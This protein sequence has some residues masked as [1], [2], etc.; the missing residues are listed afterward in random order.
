MMKLLFGSMPRNRDRWALSDDLRERLKAEV[1]REA[2]LV[3][4]AARE[5]ARRSAAAALR[6]VAAGVSVAG[7]GL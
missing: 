6:S 1:L 4:A 5:A 2:A 3:A 7:V